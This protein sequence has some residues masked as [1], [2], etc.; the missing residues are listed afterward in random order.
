MAYFRKLRQEPKSFILSFQG[1]SSSESTHLRSPELGP[2]SEAG[3][4]RPQQAGVTPWGDSCSVLVDLP[5]HLPRVLRSPLLLGRERLLSS[6]HVTQTLRAQPPRSLSSWKI[7]TF[8]TPCLGRVLK[9]RFDQKGPGSGIS[10][11][12]RHREGRKISL[13]P[14]HKGGKQCFSIPFVS[15]SGD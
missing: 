7:S 8:V 10:L 4:Q 12:L 14:F 3:S 9:L 2:H 11:H 1:L 6:S 13:T 15:S 5:R